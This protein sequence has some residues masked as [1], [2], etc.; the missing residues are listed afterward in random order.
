VCLQLVPHRCAHTRQ[1]LLH[2][3]RL[4][5]VVV[6]PKIK[7]CH[8]P[9]W[10]LRKRTGLR[11]KAPKSKAGLR[12]VTLPDILVDAP[13]DHRKAQLEFRVKRG[14]SRLPEDTLLFADING[15][16]LTPNSISS[17]W[18]DFTKSISILQVTFH[19]LQHTHASQLIDAGVDVATI[20]C[21]LGHAMPDITLRTYAHLFQKTTARRRPPLM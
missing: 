3:E 6:G 2:A 16:P 18:G 8:F 9:S 12:D 14:A 19:A 1:K 10:S 11:F 5:Q 17:A 15:C 21:R 13:C 7:G 4:R 20:S